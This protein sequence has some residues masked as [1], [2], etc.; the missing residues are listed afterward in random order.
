MLQRTNHRL[1]FRKLSILVTG[2]AAIIPAAA[3]QRGG[4]A[5]RAFTAA[6]YA[7]AERF[8]GYNTTPLVFH[9]GM[10]PTWLPDERFWYRTTTENGSEFVLIDPAR[11]TRAPA[12]DHAKVAAALSTASGTTYH[13]SSLPFTEFQ[14]S[15]DGRTISFSA[16]GRSWTCGVEGD[17][18]T[19]TDRAGATP[20]GRGAGGGRGG[21]GA[22][23][24]DNVSPDGKSAVFIRD[25]NLWVRDVATGKEKQLTTD[26]VKDFGYATDNAGWSNSDRPIVLWSP[27]SKKVATFQQDQRG[28]GE[29]YLVDT[30]RRPSAAAGLEVPAS[31]RPGGHHDPAGRH[32]AGRPAGDPA[33]DASRPAPVHALRQRRVPRRRVGRRP[34]GSRRHEARVRVHLPRPQARAAPHRGCRYRRGSRCA[35]RDDCNLLR[36]GQRPHQLARSLRV[37]RADLVLRARQLGAALSLRFADGETEEPDHDRRRERHTAAENR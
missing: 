25:W 26:G 34:V 35:R 6:D 30:T 20:G 36:V 33:E 22:P 24:N 18:C 16:G 37:E 19:G 27:D 8:M 9:A 13:A 10:R 15:A 4:E 17:K 21:P 7:R 31:G 32:R 23:R 14:F 2:L 3:Q 12:F 29:M 5:Q 11:G 1:S 28:V